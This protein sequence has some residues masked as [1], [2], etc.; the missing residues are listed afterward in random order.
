MDGAH[1]LKTNTSEYSYVCDRCLYTKFYLQV[2]LFPFDFNFFIRAVP[3][4]CKKNSFRFRFHRYLKSSGG[5]S[6]NV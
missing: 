1:I 5:I 6:E 2:F 3:T 4:E